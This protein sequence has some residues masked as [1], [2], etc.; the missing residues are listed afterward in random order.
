MNHPVV[1]GG[2]IGITEEEGRDGEQQGSC[3][4]LG[5]NGPMEPWIGTGRL[6]VVGDLFGVQSIL[7]RAVSTASQISERHE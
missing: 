4:S 5:R 7:D 6:D 1:V 2:E 3:V